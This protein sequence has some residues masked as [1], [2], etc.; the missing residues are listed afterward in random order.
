MSVITVSV[1]C[2]A[3]FYTCLD[4]NM[5]DIKQIE[6][7]TCHIRN[8]YN[9]LIKPIDLHPVHMLFNHILSLS[10]NLYLSGL[11][12]LL[13]EEEA[14]IESILSIHFY[15]TPINHR[16]VRIK[17]FII[18]LSPCTH[19]GSLVTLAHYNTSG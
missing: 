17:Q 19:G 6:E 1:K 16:P 15:T 12:Q 7:K 13:T 9:F 2:V 11:G 3:T 5:F 10:L 14:H 4:C 18:T 8:N